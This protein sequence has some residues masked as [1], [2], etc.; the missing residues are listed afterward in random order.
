MQLFRGLPLAPHI[1][2]TALAI[3]NFDGV[4]RGH[5]ALIDALK[6]HAKP[7][8]LTCAVMTFEPHPRVFFSPATA[9]ARISTLRDRLDA[10]SAHGIQTTFL[11]RF[12]QALGS[13]APRDFVTQ[14]LAGA[15][16]AKFVMVGED[17]RFG[18]RRGG[19]VAM[20]RHMGAELGFSVAALS[21]VKENDARI[22]SSLVRQALAAGELAQAAELLGRPYAITGHVVHGARLGRTLDFPTLNQR[23]AFANPAA[24]GIFAVLVHG[25]AAQPLPGVASL[26]LRPTVDNSGRW[27]LESHVFDWAGDAYG[28]IVRVELLIKLRDEERYDDLPTLQRAIAADA[29]AAR[30]YFKLAPSAAID[31]II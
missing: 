18:A 12:N 9:P 29:A 1:G 19:D 2:P 10:L 24:R 11:L 3:G 8:G 25:L 7:R 31:R 22:S 21:D 30:A 4:H 15:C 23:L 13:M 17:F 6:A 14:L 5:Q 16:N 20:L 28:K 27:L 26:G